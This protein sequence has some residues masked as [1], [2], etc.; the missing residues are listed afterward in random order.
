MNAKTAAF[1]SLAQVNS[2]EGAFEWWRSNSSVTR[3]TT[4]IVSH[5]DP[6]TLVVPVSRK[7]G[8]T[9]QLLSVFCFPNLT[10]LNDRIVQETLIIQKS[11]IAVD[12]LVAFDTNV[13]TY[14]RRLFAEKQ[15]D[16]IE[17]FRTFLK[18][19][20]GNKINWDIRSYLHENAAALLSRQHDRAIYDTVLATE[21]LSALDVDEFMNGGPLRTLRPVEELAA[22]AGAEIADFLEKLQSGWSGMIDHR[23]KSLHAAVLYMAILHRA[24]PGRQHATQKLKKMITF[25]HS[26]LSCLFLMILWA[27]W[28]WFC[29]DP[30]TS[31]FNRLQPGAKDPLGEAANISWDVYHMTQQPGMIMTSRIGGDVLIP[32]FLTGDRGLAKLWQLY[33][34]RSCWARNGLEHPFCVPAI[35]MEQELSVVTQADRNFANEFLGPEAHEMRG[36]RLRQRGSPDIPRLIARLERELGS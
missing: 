33:P 18:A 32:A 7:F 34:M 35:D 20:G 25:M 22:R 8:R 12:S 17:D 36:E 19:F 15:A 13:A 2:R 10:V 21:K 4:L 27:A 28:R 14:L 11:R 16:P 31:I 23:R 1:H 26:E 30:R 6:S 24:K 3:G 29:H 9:L 5:E